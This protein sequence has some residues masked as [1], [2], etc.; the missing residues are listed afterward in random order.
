MSVDFTIDIMDI[1]SVNEGIRRLSHL[2]KQLEKAMTDAR[3]EFRDLLRVKLQEELTRYGL[4]NSK[5]AST[6][7]FTNMS[8]GMIINVGADYGMYVEFGT[9]IVGESFPHPNPGAFGVDW[10]YDEN[11]H[12]EKGWWYPTTEADPNPVKKFSKSQQQ[13]FGFTRGLPARPF[14]YNTWLYARRIANQVFGKHIRR[15]GK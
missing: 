1:K 8:D 7:T 2:D 5:M 10:E 3:D 14:M 9:G 6:I 4:A 13:W 11:Q 15:V 12:G